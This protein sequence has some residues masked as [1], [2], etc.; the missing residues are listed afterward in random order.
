MSPKTLGKLYWSFNKK[1]TSYKHTISIKKQQQNILYFRETY[2]SI[3]HASNK[4]LQNIISNAFVKADKL[5]CLTD[6]TI[7]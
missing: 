7:I 6:N 5:F 4:S 2:A 3:F 1:G